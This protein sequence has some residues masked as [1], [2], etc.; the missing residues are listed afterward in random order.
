MAGPGVKGVSEIKLKS[1]ISLFATAPNSNKEFE[2]VLDFLEVEMLE[3]IEI[4]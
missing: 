4:F 1:F 3:N 2:K